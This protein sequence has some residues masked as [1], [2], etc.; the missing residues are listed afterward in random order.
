MLIFLCVQYS[1]IGSLDEKWLY[2]QFT[3][4]CSAGMSSDTSAKLGMPKDL[5]L[6]WPT[7]KEVGGSLE[8]WAAGNALPGYTK[9]VSKPFLQKHYRKWAGTKY[10]RER[11]MPH[12]KMYCRSAAFFRNSPE[13]ENLAWVVL[14]SHNLSKAA[15]GTLQKNETQLCIR[16]YE[17]GVL[18]KPGN[19]V[20]PLPF[21]MPPIPYT[22]GLDQ[23]WTCD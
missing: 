22:I 14:G 8:G 15:W 16:S 17:L 1:S 20:C 11:A 21:H 4:S 7:R 3:K 13:R 2:E 5:H 19:A 18:L 6:V 12:C 23:P 9:N 10:S